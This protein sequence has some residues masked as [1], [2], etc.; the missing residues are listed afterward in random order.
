M[1]YQTFLNLLFP[2]KSNRHA[3][4]R[5]EN[6]AILKEEEALLLS[7]KENTKPH[8]HSVGIFRVQNLLNEVYGLIEPHIQTNNIELFYDIHESVPIELVGD[9]LALEQILYNLLSTIVAS[10]SNSTIIVTLKKVNKTII[11]E[12]VGKHLLNKEIINESAIN[13]ETAKKFISTIQGRFS[14]SIKENNTLY[15]VTLPF[16]THEL[17]Q[18][19]YYNLPTYITSKKVLLIQDNPDIGEMIGNIFK[20][21]KL[22]IAIFSSDVLHTI[23]D[24]E[25]YDMLILDAKRMTPL[26]VTHL[27]KVTQENELKIISLETLHGFHRD[28]RQQSN[29][30]ISKYLYKPLSRGMISGL[31]HEIFVLKRD[32]NIVLNENTKQSQIPHKGQIVCI[33]ESLNITRDSFNDFGYKHILVVEDNT[34]NQKIIQRIL[35]KSHIKITLANHG[36]EA[37]DVLKKDY[38]IDLILMDINMPTMDGYQATKHIRK[39]QTLSKMPIIIISG[40]GFR[41]E[42]KEMYRVGADAHLTKPFKIG[43]LYTV[44]KN[45]IDKKYTANNVASLSSSYIENRTNLDITSAMDKV[46]NLAYYHDSLSEVLFVFRYSDH[47]IKERII[48]Q[49]YKELQEYCKRL[50]NYT[51]SIEAKSLNKLLKEMLILIKNDEERILQQYITL[52]H[53][54][55]IK[56]QRNI[57]Q[58]LKSVEVN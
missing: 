10:Q 24:F 16:L 32:E 56:T 44:L 57:K 25:S 14:I 52:Y 40:L 9:I 20:Q 2:K 31:L 53:D 54:E 29:P 30:L 15:R 55:W 5:K 7:L 34:I 46:K 13:I 12:I 45:F 11:I 38:S 18:E 27:Q 17:Y 22:H 1:I 42:I 4:T 23:R 39:D 8:K 37:L 28:R 35:E 26:L 21:F 41:N 19:N 3:K 49:E 58:Y 36:Q 51:K 47:I 33:E 50:F 6:K 48:R 43:E